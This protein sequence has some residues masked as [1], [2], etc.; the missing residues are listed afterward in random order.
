MKKLCVLAVCVLF[1]FIGCNGG[2]GGGGEDKDPC[3]GP[4]LCLD[5]DWGDQGALF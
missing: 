3:A 1:C 5:T 4:V 2:G